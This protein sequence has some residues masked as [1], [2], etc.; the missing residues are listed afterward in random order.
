MQAIEALTTPFMQYSLDI[1]NKDLTKGAVDAV[2]AIGDLHRE[3]R[4]AAI[5]SLDVALKFQGDQQHPRVD[6]SRVRKAR[7]LLLSR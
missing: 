3:A 4:G 6:L 1:T 5:H 2:Y 7:T